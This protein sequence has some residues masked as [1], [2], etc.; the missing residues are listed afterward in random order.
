MKRVLTIMVLLALTVMVPCAMAKDKPASKNVSFTLQGKQTAGWG[1]AKNAKVESKT[2]VL[3]APAKIIS[4][5]ANCR[6]YSIWSTVTPKNRTGKVVLS[7]G[8]GRKDI[9]GQTLPAGSYCVIPG[10]D[11]KQKTATV[12]ILL[13]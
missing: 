11:A 5:K 1:H 4:V 9:V 10:L 3:E 2:L 7:G 13:Q 8:K 12:T 6:A